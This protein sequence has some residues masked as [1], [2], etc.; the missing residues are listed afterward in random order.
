M[1]RNGRV[2]GYGW[3]GAASGPYIILIIWSRSSFRGC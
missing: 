2:R 3:C 1:P